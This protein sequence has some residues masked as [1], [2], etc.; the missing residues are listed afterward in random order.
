MWNARGSF[1]IRADSDRTVY[2]GKEIFCY[3]RGMIRLYQASIIGL[4]LNK[5]GPRKKEAE[6]CLISGCS[7]VLFERSPFCHLLMLH[8]ETQVV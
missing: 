1:N 4:C 8:R 5:F 6:A 2:I 3:N 7:T